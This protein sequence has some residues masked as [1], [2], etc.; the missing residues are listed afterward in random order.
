MFRDYEEDVKEQNRI[1]EEKER[2]KQLI[3]NRLLSKVSSGKAPSRAQSSAGSL[4]SQ[5]GVTSRFGSKKKIYTYEILL[6]YFLK[7]VDILLMLTLYYAGCNR[8]DVYHC[9]LLILFAIYI[10]YQ[11]GFR[12]NFKFLLY[13]MA[14][15]A[16]IK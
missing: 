2:K 1:K 14:F 7:N 15:I 6:R 12:R 10:M 3:T 5:D 11:D 8:V 4:Y 13:F 16:T 9:F